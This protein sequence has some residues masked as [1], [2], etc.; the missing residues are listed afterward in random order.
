MKKINNT[1]TLRFPDFD[2]GWEKMENCDGKNMRHGMGILYRR[3]ASRLYAT[4]HGIS[5]KCIANSHNKNNQ[6]S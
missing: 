3:D 1:P 2:G 4:P 5:A 6:P